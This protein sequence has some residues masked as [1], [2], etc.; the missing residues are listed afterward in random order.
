MTDS[1]QC[2]QRGHAEHRV[3]NI[4]DGMEPSTENPSC[5][6][7]VRANLKLGMVCFSN[8]PLNISLNMKEDDGILLIKNFLNIHF[9]FKKYNLS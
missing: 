5:F 1:V 6:S 3:M 4:L 9:L 7:E 8:L 2:R